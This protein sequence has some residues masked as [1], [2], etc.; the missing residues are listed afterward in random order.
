MVAGVWRAD[1]SPLCDGAR[2]RIGS[3]DVNF[4]M[5]NWSTHAAK[6][7]RDAAAL[8]SALVMLMVERTNVLSQS[9]TIC[10]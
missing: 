2:V 9:L 3:C 6:G 7:W 1:V 4:H 10:L 8:A 5:E